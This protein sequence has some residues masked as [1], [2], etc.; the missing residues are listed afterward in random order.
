MQKGKNR[1]SFPHECVLLLI[2]LSPHRLPEFMYIISGQIEVN[3]AK[4][5]VERR[6]RRI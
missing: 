5:M 1:G 2:S 3:L 4:G 6:S